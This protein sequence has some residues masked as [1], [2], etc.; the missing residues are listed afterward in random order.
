MN[1]LIIYD[2]KCG[3]CNRTVL[4]IAKKDKNNVF[5][6]VSSLSKLGIKLLLKYKIKGLEKLTIILIEKENVYTK[7]IAIRKMLLRTPY[8]KILGYVMFLIPKD[9]SDWFY[10]FISN[11]RKRIVKNNYC[12]IPTCEIKKK[13]II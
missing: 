9:V 5:K 10:D 1:P 7:S 12:E 8:F 13:F 11:R 4:F 2:G 6:F 3:F